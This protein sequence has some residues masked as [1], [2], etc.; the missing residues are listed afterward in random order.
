MNPSFLDEMKTRLFEEKAKLEKELGKFTHRNPKA[1]A[2]DFDADFPNLG[3]KEDENAAEVAAYSD[4]LSLEGELEKQF[5]DVLK[6][7]QL[8]EERKYGICTY[9]VEEISESR[10]RARPTSSS[11]IECKKTLTQ[12]M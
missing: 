1:V 9:C 3:D 5:R 4:N 7:L 8:I 12:E 10:L 11:C 2:V 6:A